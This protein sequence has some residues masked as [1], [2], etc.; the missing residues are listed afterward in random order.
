MT[1]SYESITSFGTASRNTED[2][3]DPIESGNDDFDYLY[4]IRFLYK[5][6]IQIIPISQLNPPGPHGT[7][8]GEII[9]TGSSMN[10][11]LSEWETRAV[12]LK[13]PRNDRRNFNR[14]MRDIF[15]EIQVMSNKSLVEHPNIVTLLGISFHEEV[16]K[17]ES[18]IYPILVVEAAHPRYPDLK[19]YIQSIEEPSPL[20][21]VYE[22]IGDIA[23][24]LA[25]LHGLGVV[26]GDIKPENIL[27][28]EGERLIAKLA[29]F[30]SCG[31]DIS[32]DP[33]RGGTEAWAPPEFSQ[34]YR[35]VG[36]ILSDVYS[37]GLVCGYLAS[38]GETPQFRCGKIDQAFWREA[39]ESCYPLSF[40]PLEPL[41]QLLNDTT[42]EI[43]KRS[44]LLAEV[45]K[46]LLGKYIP[47][48]W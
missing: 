32:K 25:A 22:L 19:Q 5:R 26:H 47:V 1:S 8:D 9:G 4:F 29:D 24:G 11:F 20:P 18:Q 17:I 42:E 14:L 44:C 23:D 15:F 34:F 10:V 35:N 13:L 6:D 30:G 28:F 38:N 40:A 7:M 45:R 3:N 41:F 43:S 39:I 12:A 37:F 48:L 33:P 36:E 16:S 46:N 2:A 31:V 27:L 21:L